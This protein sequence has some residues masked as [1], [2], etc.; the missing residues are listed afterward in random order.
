MRQ[1]RFLGI[2]LAVAFALALASCRGTDAQFSIGGTIS[3]TTG[4]VVLSLNGANQISQNGDGDFTFTLK[5]LQNQTFNV[6]VADPT[7]RCTVQNGAGTVAQSNVKDVNISCADYTAFPAGLLQI[8]VRSTNLTGAKVNPPVTTSA[9]AV[10]GV[11]VDPTD[12][13]ASGNTPVLGGVTLSG[14]ALPPIGISIN[15]A[16]KGNPTGVGPAIISLILASDGVTAVL[17]PA[18][19]LSTS[20]FASLLAGELYLNVATAVNPNGEVRG[21]IELQGGVGAAVTSLDNTQVVPPTGS[22]AFGVGALM[23]DLATSK[24]LISYIAHTVAAATGAG[25]STSQIPAGPILAFSTLQNNFDASGTNLATPVA[26]A[27]LTQQNLADFDN[28]FLFFNVTSATFPGGE[29]RG[30]ISPLPQ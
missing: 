24:I 9:T 8:V 26:G 22:A 20:E 2:P 27:V 4:T 6:Q 28:S 23:V 11:M 16:P 18:A 12:K 19:V 10:G 13:D 29:I 17:P 14:F 25:M 5:L 1:A 3:G 15:Q 30:N 21:A 7:G